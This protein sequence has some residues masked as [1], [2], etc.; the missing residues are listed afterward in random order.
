VKV[1]LLP[2]RQSIIE[3]IVPCLSGGERDYS[4]NTVVFPG[5]RPAHFLRKALAR[6]VGSGF[7]PPV[8]FSMDEFVDCIYEQTASSRKLETIDAV[9]VLYGIHRKAKKPLGG[10]GFM[11]P[12]SFFPVGMKIYRD[13]EEL[14]IEGIDPHRVKDI[15]PYAEEAIPPQTLERLQSL[16]FFYEEFYRMIGE[17]GFSTR[18][19]RYRSAAEKFDDIRKEDRRTILA[20]FFALTQSEKTLF[21]KLSVSADPVFIFHDGPGLRET[22]S[23]LGFDF[24][25]REE[26]Q[27]GPEVRFYSSPDSHGQVYALN[28]ALEESGCA[29]DEKT[30]IVLP[31]AETLFPLLRQGLPA[32]DD[33]GYNV[34]L[35]YPLHRTPVFGFLNNLMELVGS[36]EGERVYI[37][38]YLRFVLHPYTKN[39]YFSGSAEAT[40]ILFHALE[41]GLTKSR[42][43]IF[44]SLH[45]MEEDGRLFEQVIGKLSGESETTEEAI[46]KHLRS[47]HLNT[48]ERF[49]SFENVRDFAAKCTE[50]L[51]YIFN[52]STARLH[53]LF[54]PF[55]ESL[56]RS[57]DLLSRSLMK[58]V[59]FDERSSYFTFFRKY[60][61][62]CYTP[63][64]GTPLRGLQILGFLETRNLQFDRVFL[65]DANEDTLPDTKKDDTLL[66]FKARQ[67]LG[68]PTY[69]DR[70]RLAAYYFQTLVRGAKEV[71]LFFVESDARERSRFVEGLLWERQM[72]DRTTD[73]ARYIHTVRYKVRLGNPEPPAIAKTGEIVS[74]L[75]GLSFSATALD[76]Y[77]ECPARF[78]YSHVLAID[79][80]E[81]VTGDIERA[82]IGKFVHKALA[83]YFSKRTGSRLKTGDID[84]REMERLADGL[85]TEE[86]G[87]E[88]SGA[89]YL[90]K[91]QIKGRLRDILKDYYIP[92]IREKPLTI[93]ACEQ[94]IRASLGPFSLRGRLD[95]V[96]D[97]GGKTVVADYKTGS[98][99]GR[100]KIDFDALDPDDRGSWNEAIGSLQL[101]F[102]LLL[103]SENTGIGIG[104][105]EGIFLLLGKAAVDR[106]IELPL[107][108]DGK[109]ETIFGPL[110]RVILG[111][112]S[113]IVDPAVPFR[114]A[115][116]RKG[117]CPGCDF[118]YLCGTQWIGR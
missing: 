41:E 56:I 103:Y 50:I 72:K 16:S 44:S 3:E 5:R 66:P 9:S 51:T 24:E 75:K 63:F 113:E 105:L 111:L 7:I 86:Y 100:L 112:L 89:P 104:D 22:I 42:T 54:H 59:V 68:L 49:L 80:K 118:H 109:P 37:A 11:T 67:I 73:A 32:I 71:H 47:I 12:D 2:P 40:R 53:P 21:R 82:D 35:G 64:E 31:S 115:E 27:R 60:V 74:Y 57:L 43:R 87:E 10:K 6:K 52:N 18:S 23:D 65:L 116:D 97:R 99:P 15:Q 30:T 4:G 76:R 98:N 114:P 96:Q 117:I 108:G 83:G 93:I 94:D 33:N 1:L 8:I 107:F 46:R 36:M 34:S 17:E 20:G 29:P 84:L 81:E 106:G 77:L 85:F 45:G 61:M 92:L 25:A 38:D 79:R 101:P 48:I 55:S 110:R 19:L 39:I 102:Y 88:L 69:Q 62:T 70:D 14:Y 90:L 13:I 58:D 95:S 78:Y 91:K 26:E 28:R